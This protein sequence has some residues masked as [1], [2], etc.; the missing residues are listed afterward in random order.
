MGVGIVSVMHT[1]DPSC[2]MLGGA[3]TFGGAK[4][5]LG[6]RFLSRIKEEVAARAFSELAEN[7]VID[8]AT[9]GG[10]AGYI[11]MSGS[12]SALFD[13]Q[14]TLVRK[15]TGPNDDHFDNFIK[16]VRSRK[17]TDLNADILG[18]HL[19]AGLCHLGN[20][21]YL[22]G[23]KA[24]TDEIA[25]QLQQR[26]LH[27]DSADTLERTCEHLKANNVD[28][29]KTQLTLGP[30][31]KLDPKTERF[32]DNE[33]ANTMLTRKYRKPFTLPTADEV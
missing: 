18:G 13:R 14:G 26:T 15:F 19:S 9:L 3:M 8:F 27:D 4:S 23:Q 24:S 1:I 20:I 7:T 25:N 31:L 2:V 22:L 16:A 5:E 17:R 6:Q 33:N 11:G 10:D 12:N 29:T 28:L 32:I 30:W 21:S